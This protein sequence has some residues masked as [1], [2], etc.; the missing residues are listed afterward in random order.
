[1]TKNLLTLALAATLPAAA[2]DLERG[3]QLFEKCY[4]CHNVQPPSGNDGPALAGVVGRAS[5]SL[6][7]FRYSKPMSRANL[8]WDEA[9]LDRYLADPPTVVPGTRMAFDGLPNAA[10][11][12]SV[13]AY[14][15]TLK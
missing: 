3:R 8:T 13:I 2:Q 4:A 11:R 15:K 1:M 6:E 7:D 10:D 9:T 5:A 12:A 14:L